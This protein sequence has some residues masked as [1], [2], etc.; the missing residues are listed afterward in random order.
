MTLKNVMAI[1]KIFLL[2]NNFK[3]I[4]KNNF[5]KRY[6]TI[7]KNIFLKKNVIPKDTQLVNGSSN[8]GPA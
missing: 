6:Q 2:W 3:S 1:L 7:F 4:I 5:C 8:R